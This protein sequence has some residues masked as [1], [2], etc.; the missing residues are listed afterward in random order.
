MVHVAMPNRNLTL[1]EL[2]LARAL[3]KDIR[4]RLTALA[5]GDSELLFAYRRKI[6]KELG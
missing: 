6:A 1:D 5:A 2:E 4:E 3:L